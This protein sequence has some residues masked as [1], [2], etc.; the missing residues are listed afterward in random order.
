LFRLV[1][2]RGVVQDGI[3]ANRRPSRGAA[4]PEPH[5]VA[6]ARALRIL[7]VDDHAG[8]RSVFQQLLQR[9]ELHIV[10]EACDGLEA[11]AKAHALRPDVIL[12]DI[13][14]PRMDGVEATRR[15]RAEL[16]FIQV[17]GLS[18]Y[19]KTKDRHPIELAGAAGFFT[20]AVDTQRLIDHLMAV[21]ATIARESRGRPA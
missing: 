14:M 13:S 20:K 19:Q 1:A 8:V 12:M 10:G 21:H 15:I 7:M 11:I 4:G 3:D 17:L 16:P 9:P 2:P 18:T 6:S 5:G